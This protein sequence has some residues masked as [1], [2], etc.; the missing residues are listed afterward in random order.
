[1]DGKDGTDGTDG[2]YGTDGTHETD[3]TYETDGMNE[4]DRTDRMDGTDISRLKFPLIS[5]FLAIIPYVSAVKSPKCLDPEE[6]QVCRY[7]RHIWKVASVI[8]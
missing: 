8:C 5:I 3:E 4:T 1:M 7:S 2:T 6:Y